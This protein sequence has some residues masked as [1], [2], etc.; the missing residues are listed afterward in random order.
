MDLKRFGKILKEARNANGLTQDQLA[1]N[2]NMSKSMISGMERGTTA[3]SLETLEKIIIEL[4]VDARRFFENNPQQSEIIILAK[5]IQEI[6]S[7]V[8]Q[9][10][11]DDPLAYLLNNQPI[12]DLLETIKLWSG[13]QINRMRDFSYAYMM[14]LSD[15]SR[16]SR[17]SPEQS[18]K[19]E[20][21]EAVS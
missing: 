9:K 8:K 13:D 15:R 11:E 19:K 5:E 18:L 7:R 2:F 6:K 20:K 17:A 1:A 16:E 10:K 4:K 12:R 3:P 14:G 21:E